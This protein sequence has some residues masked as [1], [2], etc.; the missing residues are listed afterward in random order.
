MAAM[1][2]SP[3]SSRPPIAASAHDYP[4]RPIRLLHGFAAGGAADTMS[5]IVWRTGFR[6]DWASRYRGSQAGRRAA[7]SPPTPIAKA[8]PDG[9]TI[10]LVTGAH[11]ISGALYKTL[12]YSHRQLRDDFDRWSITRW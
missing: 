1:L 4:N 9:Y 6:S 2:F 10:G 12:A 3:A 7:I 5:R 8:E 11:A